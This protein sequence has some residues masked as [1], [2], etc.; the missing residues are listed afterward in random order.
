M[1]PWCS[2]YHRCSHKAQPD[3]KSRSEVKFPPAGMLAKA[4]GAEPHTCTPDWWLWGVV[5][6]WWSYI[7][8][9]LTDSTHVLGRYIKVCRLSL[10][11]GFGK[12]NSNSYRAESRIKWARPWCPASH[13]ALRTYTIWKGTVVAYGYGTSL[14]TW[15][16][17][18][19][20][21]YGQWSPL[22]PQLNR[23]SP[24]FCF[25]STSE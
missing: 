8:Q 7:K 22:S 18:I 20:L 25:L 23:F 17:G 4:L 19:N 5:G 6:E 15:G 24:Y 2:L 12:C 11:A 13:M 10:C 16:V 14:G 3:V 9:R 21:Q 1:C